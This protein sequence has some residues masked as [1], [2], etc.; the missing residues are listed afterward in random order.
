MNA[1]TIADELFRELGEPADISVPSIVFWIIGNIGVLNNYLGTSFSIANPETYP[2]VSPEI[3]D[4]QKVVLKT[5]Y[6]IHYFARQVNKNLGAAAYQSFMEVKEGNRTVRRVNKT[7]IAK[8][9]GLQ[10]RELKDDL[11]GMIMGYKMNL[12]APLQCSVANPIYVE[13]MYNGVS[14]YA[15]WGSAYGWRRS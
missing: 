7:D 2:A 9:Y 8:A 14:C 11:N 12:A 6:W 10:L 4:N 15:P 3:N 5:I 13:A 1:T